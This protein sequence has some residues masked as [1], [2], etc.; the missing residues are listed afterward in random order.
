MF[1]PKSK[2]TGYAV[3]ADGDKKNT[4]LKVWL[5]DERSMPGNFDVHARTPEE[6]INLLKQNIVE[7]ISLDHDLGLPDPLN[8]GAV[9]RWIEEHANAG[10]LVPLAWN[11]HTANPVGRD[12]MVAALMN[13]DRFWASNRNAL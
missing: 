10:D 6:A 3:Y 1:V 2:I 5:D 9:A 13:A 11:V 12:E 4:Y 7:Y 8:G